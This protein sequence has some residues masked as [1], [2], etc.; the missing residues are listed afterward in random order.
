MPREEIRWI[1]AIRGFL[2]FPT[3]RGFFHLY[4]AGRKEKERTT[5]RTNNTNPMHTLFEE[6]GSMGQIYAGG[7]ARGARSAPIHIHFRSNFSTN[8]MRRP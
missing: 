4:S 1:R 8:E 7:M 6:L 3:S 2:S 5:N